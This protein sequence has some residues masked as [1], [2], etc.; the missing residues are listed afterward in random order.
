MVHPQ[1]NMVKQLSKLVKV[2]YVEDITKADRIG[3]PVLHASHFP[4]V[5][6]VLQA[7]RD[8]HFLAACRA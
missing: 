1:A 4:V 5:T 6:H 7:A 8:P 2:R 3:V